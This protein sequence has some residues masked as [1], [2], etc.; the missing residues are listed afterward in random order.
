MKIHN[1]GLAIVVEIQLKLRLIEAER[2][3]AEGKRIKLQRGIERERFER[4]MEQMICGSCSSNQSHES[5]NGFD[6]AICNLLPIMHDSDV[7]SF[8]HAL[9]KACE[10]KWHS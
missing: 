5:S 3:A 9:E 4:E 10:L 1:D 2:A 7:L 6:R 8:F